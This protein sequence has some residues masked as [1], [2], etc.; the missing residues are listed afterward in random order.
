MKLADRFLIERCLAQWA[1]A[2][3]LTPYQDTIAVIVVSNIAWHSNDKL[4]STE[5][6]HTDT[7]LFLFFEQIRIVNTL[8][9]AEHCL[10]FI[11]SS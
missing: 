9:D 3:V 2:L 4:A 8:V 5:L 6:L 7:A 11:R 10:Y 1:R